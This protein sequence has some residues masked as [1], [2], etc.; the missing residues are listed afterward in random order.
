MTE[1]PLISIV[2]IVY[3]GEKHLQ[4]T[5]DSVKNQTYGNIEYIIVDGESSDNTLTIIKN[6]QE[7]ISK[8]VSEPDNGLYDAMN[9]GIRMATGVLIGMINSDDWYELDAVETVV[10]EF[11][12]HPDKKIFHSDRYDVHADGSKQIYPFNQSVFK[13]K[14]FSMT[15]NHPTMFI[16]REIYKQLEYNSKLSSISDYQL[17]LEC[18]LKNKN[19]FHYI[20]KAISNFRLGGISGQLPIKKLLSEN[21]KARKN[22]GMNY[23]ECFFAITLRALGEFYKKTKNTLANN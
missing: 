23:F 21:F 2:T 9:K 7:N 8:W 17:V 13:F 14:Y 3:N 1:L 4:Q 20:P 5:I 12:K 18:Y 6:N 11:L 19:D 15:Y 22:A 16:H 10:C